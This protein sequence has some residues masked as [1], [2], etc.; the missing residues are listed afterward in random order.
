MCIFAAVTLLLKVANCHYFFMC[1]FAAVTLSV[2]YIYKIVAAVII[3]SIYSKSGSIYKR[4]MSYY[5]NFAMS[6][7]AGNLKECPFNAEMSIYFHFSNNGH[8]ICQK[9]SIGHAGFFRELLY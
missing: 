8:S 7:Y 3:W 9:N 2:E 1:I 4:L 5:M 6:L